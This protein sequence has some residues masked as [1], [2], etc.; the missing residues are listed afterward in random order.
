MNF[1]HSVEYVR[2]HFFPKWDTERNWTVKE[3]SDDE[4]H[5]AFGITI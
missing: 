5:G 2:K 4:I 3:C 1:N